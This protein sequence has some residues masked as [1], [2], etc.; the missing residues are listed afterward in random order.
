[1]TDAAERL[2]LALSDRYTIESVLGRGGARPQ[3]TPKQA[4]ELGKGRPL[5]MPHQRPHR[6]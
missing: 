6:L 4:D 1:M 2:A 3:I 5:L